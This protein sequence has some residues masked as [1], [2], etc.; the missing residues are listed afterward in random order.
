MV[1]GAITAIGNR[2]QRT[3]LPLISP[4]LVLTGDWITVEPDMAQQSILGFGASFTDAAC[5]VLSRMDQVSRSRLLHELFHPTQASLQVCRLCIGASDYA[6]TA[7][8]Y[9]DVE[10]DVELS[11]F[12][13]DYDRAYIIPVVREALQVNPD[14]FLFSSPWSPPGWMKTGG[15]MLGGW[16]RQQYLS[17]YADYM[18]RYL[19]AYREAG[20]P[21]R[22][23]TVQNETETDQLGQMPACY[24]HPEHEAEFVLHHLAPRLEANGLDV[25][26]WILDHNYVMWKRAKWMLDHAPLARVVDGVGFH[27]YQGKPE[28]MSM[29]HDAHPHHHVY[30]TEGGPDLGQDYLHNWCHWGKT[31]TDALRNWS[32]SI[33]AWNLALDERGEPNIGPF[34]CAGL[35]TVEEDGKGV[36]YSGQYAALRHFSSYVKPHAVRVLSTEVDGLSNV[37][38]I[39]PDGQ[40][41]VVLTNPKSASRRIGIACAGQ[42]F[43]VQLEPNSMMTVAWD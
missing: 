9:D 25:L 21:I 20:V 32:R 17:V 34:P 36:L 11:H 38:F 35:V 4:E 6:R 39:N 3:D 37:A 7:Y 43:A 10:D 40:K 2:F 42:R 12:S 27:A 24:W 13:I 5:Y 14:L 28:M 18:V 22:G 30:W 41:V 23:I 29:L 26:V 16:M 15:S 19:Q 8:S 1:K 31:F 33:T